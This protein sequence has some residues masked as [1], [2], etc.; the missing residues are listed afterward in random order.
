LLWHIVRFDFAGIE[1]EVRAEVEAALTGLDAI[2]VVRWR[3]VARDVEEPDVTGL[4]TVF[5]DAAALAAYRVHPDHL[6]VVERIR[7]L[8]IPTVRLDVV[9][10]DAVEELQ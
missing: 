7:E 10:D 3:R 2:D 1:D 5:E 8:G 4:L 9:T 6:P